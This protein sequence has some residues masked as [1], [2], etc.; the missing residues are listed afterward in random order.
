MA[1][2]S[3]RG[4]RETCGGTQQRAG[5]SRHTGQRAA[6]ALHGNE[7]HQAGLEL[8]ARS[9]KRG[10]HDIELKASALPSTQLGIY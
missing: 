4:I 9:I 10:T 1:R 6:H 2:G 3:E 8:T 5:V 7:R